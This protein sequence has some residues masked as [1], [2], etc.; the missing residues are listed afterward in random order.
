M[1]F[2]SLL[3]AL[4]VLSLAVP[5]N[6]RQISGIVVDDDSQTHFWPASS[7]QDVEKI[8]SL[9]DNLVRIPRVEHRLFQSNPR[10]SISRR[11]KVK[12]SAMSPDAVAANEKHERGGERGG[13]GG[14]G[15]V[16]TKRRFRGGKGKHARGGIFYRYEDMPGH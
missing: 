13:G 2:L 10:N 1:S 9:E 3:L 4:A 15:R 7:P 14:G 6:A 12:R 11:N 5:A 8:D 16:H